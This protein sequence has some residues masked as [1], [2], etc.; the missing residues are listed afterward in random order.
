MTSAAGV[1]ISEVSDVGRTHLVAA[2]AA[3][4]A[5]ERPEAAAADAAARAEETASGAGAGLAKAAPMKAER[6]KVFAS[7]LKDD[8]LIKSDFVYRTSE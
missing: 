5:A 6:K 4:E 2:A 8:D 3:A 7:I 1:G